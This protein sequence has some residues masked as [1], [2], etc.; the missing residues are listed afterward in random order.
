MLQ[1]AKAIGAVMCEI[2]PEA[3]NEYEALDIYITNL[4]K[5]IMFK[6][7]SNIDCKDDIAFLLA[8]SEYSKPIAAMVAEREAGAKWKTSQYQF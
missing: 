5:K 3:M 1:T 6:R 8:L 4:Y 2:Y 7:R